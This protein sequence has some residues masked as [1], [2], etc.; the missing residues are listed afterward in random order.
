MWVLSDPAVHRYRYQIRWE[1]CDRRYWP[2]TRRTRPT[3]GCDPRLNSA[4]RYGMRGGWRMPRG[5]TCQ[6]P[7]P[8]WKTHRLHRHTDWGRRPSN[9]GRGLDPQHSG[10]SLLTGISGNVP[11]AWN[12]WDIVKGCGGC[13]VA[14]CYMLNAGT[15]WLTHTSRGRSTETPTRPPA[16]FAAA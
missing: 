5:V 7:D 10:P 4:I 2:S 6:Q 13:S 11:Y 1:I 16:L 12:T 9:D 15:E 3:F 14:T 8:R